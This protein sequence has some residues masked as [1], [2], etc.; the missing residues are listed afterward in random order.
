MFILAASMILSLYACGD[1]SN[2]GS[3]TAAPEMT[4]ATQTTNVPETTDSSE[5]SVSY[6][7]PSVSVKQTEELRKIVVD[8]MYALSAVEWTPKEDIYFED[9]HKQTFEAGKTYYGL[10]YTSASN[11]TLKQFESV[12]KDGV[13]IGPVDYETAVGTDCS[14]AVFGAWWQICSSTTIG[15]PRTK[16]ALPNCGTGVL[17]VGDYKYDVPVKGTREIIEANSEQT[18][19]ESYAKLQLGDAVIRYTHSGHI[20]MVTG[21]VRTVLDSD[22]KID[23]EK[24]YVITT[25]QGS[26]YG[27]DVNTT[28]SVDKKYTFKQLIDVGYIPITCRELVTGEVYSQTYEVTGTIDPEKS[29]GAGLVGRVKSNYQI[30]AVHTLVFDSDGNT[31]ID[32]YEFTNNNSYL[33]S[34]SKRLKNSVLNLKNGEYTVS[35]TINTAKGSFEVYRITF[36]K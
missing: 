33:F 18:I 22:N 10:P 30:F 20:R 29:A 35:I 8:H 19:Y 13:Y 9:F 27:R 28:W 7:T 12:L 24:S 3:D 21:E 31:V 6:E 2:A 4:T 34:S 17:P 11:G 16:N 14:S 5:M 25:E 23:P 32:N 26:S 1:S 36:N 15:A